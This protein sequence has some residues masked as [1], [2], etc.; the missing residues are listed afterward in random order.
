MIYATSDIHG[1]P[2]DSFLDLL[3]KADFGPSDHLYVIGD[4][5]DRNGDGG[6]AMLRWM[7]KQPNV[8]MIRGNHESMML[9]CEFLFD[10]D[11][12]HFSGKDLSPEQQHALLLWNQNGALVTITNL[13]QLKMTDPEEFNGLMKYVRS[14]PLY[15]QLKVPMKSIVLVH[16]G[17][18]GFVPEKPLDEYSQNDLVWIRPGIEEDYW[19][20]RL[21]ILGH[22]P[23]QYYGKKGKAFV[24]P[25]WIDID[26]GAAAGGS[27]ML[28]RLD[29]LA[30]F[31][32]ES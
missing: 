1:Y 2:L 27:P 8:T 14:T 24:T 6:V 23:T 31:Y 28:L 18:K 3:K 20:D 30:E 29:D 13:T 16:G 21:V 5:I 12:E 19:N 25:T 9:D 15:V 17:F 32:A 11:L 26:T 22:T 7:M 4:V 10:L